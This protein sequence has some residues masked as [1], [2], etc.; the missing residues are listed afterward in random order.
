MRHRAAQ[1]CAMQA[2]ASL[3]E[4]MGEGNDDFPRA[5]GAPAR[6]ALLAAGYTS[7]NDLVGLSEAAL[8]SLHGVGPKALRVLREALAA[9]TTST[10]RPTT[11]KR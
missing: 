8:L 1:V 11:T 2:H 3:E 5:M 6:R 10:T 7:L 9:R 4:T